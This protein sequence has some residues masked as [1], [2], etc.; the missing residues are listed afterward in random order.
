MQILTKLYT[1]HCDDKRTI[2]A[3]KKYILE[4]TSELQD[5]NEQL[6]SKQTNSNKTEIYYRI[7][8]LQK[9]IQDSKEQLLSMG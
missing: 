7:S 3:L 2:H 8:F 9:E 6:K 5:L 4:S 1:M